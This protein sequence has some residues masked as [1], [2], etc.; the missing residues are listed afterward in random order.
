MNDVET[1]LLIPLDFQNPNHLSEQLAQAEAYQAYLIG[2]WLEG[3]KDT[4]SLTGKYLR[5]I[6]KRLS[7]GQTFLRRTDEEMKRMLR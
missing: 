3:D 7:L 6:E 1:S 2:L 5:A 4:R